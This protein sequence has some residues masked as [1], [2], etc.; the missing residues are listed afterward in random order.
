MSGHMKSFQV[1][2]NVQMASV[3]RMGRMLGMTTD[4]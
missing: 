3:A 2:R 1:A 4:Q